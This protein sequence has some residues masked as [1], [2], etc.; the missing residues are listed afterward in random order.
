MR[1]LG[2]RQLLFAVGAVV[3]GISSRAA[4]PQQRRFS[5]AFANQNEE[6]GVR[7]DGLG[8]SGADVRRGFDLAARTLP[9]DL[10]HYDNAGDGEKA[11]ANADDAIA[12]KAEL[13]IAYGADAEANA[14]IGRKMKAAGIPVLA[15]NYP[16]PGAPLYTADNLA[17]GHLAGKALGEHARQNH[18]G[19]AIVAVVVGD[20]SD[21]R[22]VIADR[23]QGIIDGLQQDFPELVPTRLDTSGNPVRVEGLLIKFLK[24]QPQRKVLIAALDD[25]TALA[26]KGAVELALRLGDCVIV[27]H[28]VDRSI[29]GGASDKKELDPNNRGSIV[30]GSVAFFLDRY[31]YEVLPL[32]LKLLRGEPIPFRSAT[33]HVLVTARNV[34]EIYPPYDMN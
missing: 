31:G 11:L 17:A 19:Q 4:L 15:V 28:G 32:A 25:P 22:T 23:V 7:L 14:E 21:V 10:I 20:L 27:G 9:V 16:V 3:A 12:R 1:L 18:S 6:P 24:A 34:F 5:I 30:L 29:H 33:R 2:R 26:A 8:F 13:F